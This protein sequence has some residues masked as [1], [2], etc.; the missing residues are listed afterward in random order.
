MRKVN[1]T[2]AVTQI[3]N[4]K[5]VSKEELLKIVEQSLISAYKK[6]FGD[7]D[8]FETK[9]D[10]QK[11]TV[12]LFRIMQVVDEV[13]NPNY[14]VTL[15]EA[16]KR[17]KRAKVGSEV[18]YEIKPKDMGRI[19]INTAK[20][21]LMQNVK[22]I[23][24]NNL[25]N[26]FKEKEGHLVSGIFQRVKGNDVF[27]DLGKITAILPRK[28]QSSG[29]RFKRGE[30][31]RAYV[32]EVRNSPRGPEVILSR[33]HPNF[34]AKLFE[35]E[36]PEIYEGAV[37][38]VSIAREAGYKCKVAVTAPNH[39]IDP[40]GACVGMRGV[41][42]QAVIRELEGEKID[43]LNYEESNF[44]RFLSSTVAPATVD[45]I[46]SNPETK[47]AIIVVPDLMLSK[48]IGR[49]GSNIKL[50]SQ[51]AGWK[52]DVKSET[53]YSEDASLIT[54]QRKAVAGLFSD[55]SAKGEADEEIEEMV[56]EET[57]A[58]ADGVEM[59]DG[60]LIDELPELGANSIEKLKA[61]GIST[62]ELLYTKTVADLTG[63]HG[64][65]QDEA[66]RIKKVL[67]ENVAYEEE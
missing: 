25:Y 47:T 33:A 26:E 2:D 37:K 45:R 36:V 65:S 57:V 59:E 58:E 4:I 8:N 49:R 22:E 18:R 52:I 20:Q 62:V 35:M 16:K 50:A 48:A 23:E 3:N 7:L 29:D 55:P 42:V 17:T 10:T 46:F 54:E 5:G 66:E 40:V 34:V 27:V 56:I 41:R 30:R 67:I 1:F 39:D 21:V 53:E 24:N 31:I 63:I 44:D 9:I 43:L 28:E 38:I 6:R 64:I 12:R 11:E 19:A 32:K 14:E 51:V 15:E 60:I 13:D 61:A